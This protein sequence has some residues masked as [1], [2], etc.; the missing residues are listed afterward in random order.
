VALRLRTALAEAIALDGMTFHLETSVG[1]A[2]YPEDAPGVEL[3]L[4]RADVAM[5]LAKERQTGVETYSSAAEQARRRRVDRQIA[6]GA[7]GG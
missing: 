6:G 1:I 5:Y 7:P 4:Q 2:L 3:L